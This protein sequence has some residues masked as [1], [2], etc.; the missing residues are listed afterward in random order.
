M[1]TKVF[2]FSNKFS[3]FRI[4][5]VPMEKK[6]S[7]LFYYFFDWLLVCLTKFQVMN[8]IVRELTVCERTEMHFCVQRRQRRRSRS[9]K[10]QTQ[11]AGDLRICALRVLRILQV[12]L[13]LRRWRSTRKK[14]SLHSDTQTN[15]LLVRRPRK[16]STLSDLHHRTHT[17]RVRSC[18]LKA[19]MGSLSGG[20]TPS[21]GRGSS[22]GDHS[23]FD[24][25]S[26]LAQ[27]TLQI[28]ISHSLTSF[29][30]KRICFQFRTLSDSLSCC[31]SHCF[32]L[33][34]NSE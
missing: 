30:F 4:S 25:K 11:I 5:K 29:Y 16:R 10:R 23:A 20:N 34:K 31:A 7:S 2:E 26:F 13:L 6:P 9:R 27:R 1:T 12:L 3:K 21:A 28:R 24:R 15:L 33:Q 8:R 22:R 18:R 17:L 14:L 32:S 19:A